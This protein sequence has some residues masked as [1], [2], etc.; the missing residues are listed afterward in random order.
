MKFLSDAPGAGWS[1]AAVA[2]RL[3]LATVVLLP[4]VV[5]FGESWVRLCL[6]VYAKVFSWVVPEFRLIDMAIATEGADR[7][8][9]A[10]VTLDRMVILGNR[11][12]SPDP[13]G[14]AHATTLAMNALLGPAIALMTAFVWPVRRRAEVAWRTLLLLPLATLT[15]L[16]DAPC[17]LAAELWA[18]L[19][20]ASEAG[21]LSALLWWKGFLQGG[22][23]YAMGIA[24]G[25]TAVLSCSRARRISSG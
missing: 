14:R 6:P 4:V 12:F 11:V 21:D 17:V 16:V 25:V 23:R 3:V 18:I 22:G 20:E 7:V 2:W 8:V 24:L 13:R 9:R 15:M 19:R 1:G 10:E 5:L